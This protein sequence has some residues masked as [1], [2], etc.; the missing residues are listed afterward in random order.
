MSL[1]RHIFR[2]TYNG[3]SIK[4]VNTQS[5]VHI[6]DNFYLPTRGKVVKKHPNCVNVV[7]ECP[8]LSTFL[9]INQS[10][11]IVSYISWEG[12]LR[13]VS[14]LKSTISLEIFFKLFITPQKDLCVQK[15]INLMCPDTSSKA[16]L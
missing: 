16:F 3:A 14:Y 13:V 9:R 12:F 15:Y 6:I 5:G 10:S 11:G 4:Y 2:L 7:Y 1:I 8:Y